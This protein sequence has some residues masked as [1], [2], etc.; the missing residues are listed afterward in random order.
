M[1]L[2]IILKIIFSIISIQIKSNSKSINTVERFK[3]LFML[4]LPTLL[5]NDS[6]LN[7]LSYKNLVLGNDDILFYSSDNT[8]DATP[9]SNWNPSQFLYTMKYEYL[10]LPCVNKAYICTHNQFAK[11]YKLIYPELDYEVRNLFI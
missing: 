8:N 4:K 3:V 9:D 10:D 6:P 11:E 1:K 2:I 7:T 5:T